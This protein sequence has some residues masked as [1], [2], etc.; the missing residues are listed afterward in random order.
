MVTPKTLDTLTALATPVGSDIMFI[1]D[2]PASA[3]LPRKVTLTNL[4]KVF[5]TPEIE[6]SF[7]ETTSFSYSHNRGAKPTVSVTDSD[8]FEMEVCVRHIDVN[9]VTVFFNGTI[10]SGKLILS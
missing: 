7:T 9:S 2:D 4:S 10:T 6:V 5:G 8:G 3:Q 1:M